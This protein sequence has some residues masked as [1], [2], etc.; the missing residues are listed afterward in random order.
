MLAQKTINDRQQNTTELT[1]T[2]TARADNPSTP[3]ISSEWSDVG[4]L[5]V[6]VSVG[7]DVGCVVSFLQIGKN[8]ALSDSSSHLPSLPD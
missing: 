2:A 8:L 3:N 1:H 5:V 6:G 7:C 4:N